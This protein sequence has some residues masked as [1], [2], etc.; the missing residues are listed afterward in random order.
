[1]PQTNHLPTGKELKRLGFKRREQAVKDVFRR[2]FAAP[3]PYIVD[4]TRTKSPGFGE[5][6]PRVP[7]SAAYASMMVEH[8]DNWG[9]MESP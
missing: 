3:Q 2:S 5:S 7:Q 4:A 6:Q 1:M 9:N 8:F